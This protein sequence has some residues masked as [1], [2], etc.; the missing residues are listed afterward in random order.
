MKIFPDFAGYSELDSLLYIDCKTCSVLWENQRI[1]N[2]LIKNSQIKRSKTLWNQ[3]YFITAK[4]IFEHFIFDRNCGNQA[5]FLSI[6]LVFSSSEIIKKR[7]FFVIGT[8]IV[9][10]DV[11]LILLEG[12]RNRRTYNRIS[13][14]RV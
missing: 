9:L 14:F 8:K 7:F 12:H 3:F 4:N 10:H 1:I 2:F 5:F 6:G 13:D 11:I